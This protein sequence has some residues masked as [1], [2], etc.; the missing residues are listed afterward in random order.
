MTG[1]V[2]TGSP[3]DAVFLDFAKAFDKVPHR[4]LISKLL[5]HGIK[6]KV[7]A[8]IT[9]WLRG[10]R[11]RVCLRGSLSDWLAVLSGVPQGSVLGPILFLIFINDLDYGIKNYILKFADDTKIF[12]S[13]LN[14]SDFC[15]LQDDINSLVKWSEDWQMLFNI[16]KCKVMHFGR[17]NQSYDYHMSNSKLEVVTE[18]KDLGVWIS[19]D[20]KVSHHCL[21]AYSKASKLLGVLNR[22]VK[23]KDTENLLFLQISYK[24]SS[25]I[26][27]FSMVTLLCQGQSTHRKN[28]K[29][30]YKNVTTFETPPL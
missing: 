1:L 15:Q 27:Y 2:D 21:Q 24:T 12:G 9:E 13:I 6:G 29:T 4:R 26:L 14:R 25:G 11:Q 18:E 19:Q 5:S 17:A 22:T 28:P 3:V 20:L 7:C 8:W 23:C 16:G 30:L 10:R